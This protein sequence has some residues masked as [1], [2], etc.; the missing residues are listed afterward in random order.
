LLKVKDSYNVTRLSIVAALAA[1]DDYAWMQANVARVRRTR[2][3]LIDGLESM[4][5]VVLPSQANFVLARR[6]GRRLEDVYR[7]LKTRGILVRYF[8]V[9]ELRDAL[10]ITVGTDVEV[11][12]LRGVL[13]EIP[14]A[15]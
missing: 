8:D 1:L 6:P 4:G 9:P 13:R 3:R 15:S 7:G 5:F 10:R 2:Q 12:A 11:D 14:L